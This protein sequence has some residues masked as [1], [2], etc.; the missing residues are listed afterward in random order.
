ML[1]GPSKQAPP[2]STQ[3]DLS[4]WSGISDLRSA[5]GHA[6]AGGISM[7]QRWAVVVWMLLLIVNGCSYATWWKTVSSSG[8]ID[9]GGS[10]AGLSGRLRARHGGDGLLG[11]LGRCSAP[12]QVANCPW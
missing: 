8:L 4:G 6:R 7:R 12:V 10:R 11:A 5:L 2:A 9:A 1:H 3:A